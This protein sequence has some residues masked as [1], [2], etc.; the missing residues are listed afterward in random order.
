MSQSQSPIALRCQQ[1]DVFYGHGAKQHQAVS[2]VSFAV[3]QGESFG[4]VGGSGCGKSTILRVLAGLDSQWQ[5]EIEVMGMARS[6]QK[7]PARAYRRQVQMVFQDPFASLHPRHTINRTL[8]EPLRVHGFSDIDA[9]ILAALD[10]V[11]LDRSFRFR[12]PHQL[13]GGQRQR[14]AIARA[15]VLEP[16][17]LLLDEPTSALDASVQ[18]EVLNVLMDV[19]RDLGTTFVFVSHDWGVVAHLCDRV[20]VMQLGQLV[21]LLSA[22]QLIEQRVTHPYTQA[23]LDNSFH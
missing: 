20:G 5:G 19:R 14:V 22:Q 7:H 3:H 1:L 13:S 4:L 21:E 8:F 17:I 16:Q 15:L 10:R 9:R 12:F 23:L 6:P 18:A 2:A 11:G